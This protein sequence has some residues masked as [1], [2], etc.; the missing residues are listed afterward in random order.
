MS[1]RV[2]VIGRNSLLG[3][4]IADRVA[5]NVREGFDFV[6][7][8]NFDL[9]RLNEVRKYFVDNDNE[10][11]VKCVAYTLVYKAEDENHIVDATNNGVVRNLA[12]ICKVLDMRIYFFN[13]RN[14]RPYVEEDKTEPLNAYG[15]TKLAG[16]EVLREI[17]HVG[18]VIR[19]S[20]LYSEYGVNFVKKL[21]G[22]VG[23]RGKSMWLMTG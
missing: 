16:E 14:F 2:L 15:K 3:F 5:R 8:D 18:V 17:S 22:Y 10:L 7:P 1:N 21:L 23:I 6:G 4:S 13:G 12:E 19:T 20:W 9:T 11:M